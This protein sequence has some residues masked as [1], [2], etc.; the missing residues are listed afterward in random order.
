MQ[1]TGQTSTQLWS[2][3][4]RQRAVITQVTPDCSDVESERRRTTSRVRNARRR[5][6]HEVCL[7]HL[8]RS[9]AGFNQ[10]PE[11]NAVLAE[12]GPYNDEIKASGHFVT[13]EALTLPN[14]AMTVRVRDGRMS[15]TDGPFMETKEMLAGLF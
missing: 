3:Q 15:A 11:S 13:S 10:S 6:Q 7:P 12:V 9:P 2:T 14:E 4:S 8:F 5:S 1:S